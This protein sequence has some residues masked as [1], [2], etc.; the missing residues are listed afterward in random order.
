MAAEKRDD[1]IRINENMVKIAESDMETRKNYLNKKI[2]LYERQ[3]N[4]T[5]TY[6]EKM[7]KL[8]EQTVQIQ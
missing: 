4:A 6:E 1:A 8:Q 2:E 5:I 7:L 3:V